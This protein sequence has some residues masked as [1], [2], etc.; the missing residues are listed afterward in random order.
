[1]GYKAVRKG[2]GGDGRG[3]GVRHGR[4]VHD[5]ARVVRRR[6]RKDGSDRWDPWISESGRANG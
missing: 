5:D 4:R 6:F 1:V 3:L 2:R